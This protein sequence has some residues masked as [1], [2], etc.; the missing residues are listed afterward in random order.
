MVGAI[1]ILLALVSLCSA[2]DHS[3]FVEDL[4]LNFQM[5]SGVICSGFWSNSEPG[6]A[7]NL[8]PQRSLMASHLKPN[9][10]STVLDLMGFWVCQCFVMEQEAVESP[11][12]QICPK[13]HVSELNYQTRYWTELSDLWMRN[14]R[15]LCRRYSRMQKRNSPGLTD[16]N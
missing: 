8:V 16:Q 12:G 9:R 2:W 11:H 14:S 1:H 10:K 3:L 15:K 4:V 13:H 6:E 5:H 7:S